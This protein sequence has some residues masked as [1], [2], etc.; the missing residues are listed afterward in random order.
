MLFAVHHIDPG[1]IRTIADLSLLPFTD[2]DDLQ[3]QNQSFIC[4]SSEKII[5]YVTTSGTLGE[6]V[7]V[8]MTEQDLDRLAWNECESLRCAGGSEKEIFQLM[9]TIDRRFMAGLAYFMGARKLGA[10]V[11]RVGNGAPQLQWD[12]IAR[13]KPTI[14]I[15][16]PSFLVKLL[17]YA[18]EHGIDPSLS[19]VR[20]AVCI[21]EPIRN[22]DFT[23]NSLGKKISEQWGIGLYSTYASTEMGAAFTECEAGR[24]GHYQPDLL[25][26][27]LIGEDDKPVAPGQ[28]GELVITTLGV[29]GMPLIRFRTGD[30]CR[31]H[32]EPCSCGRPSMRLGP[33]LGR[34]KQMIKY[35][36]TSL[37]P[38]A[39]CNILNEIPGVSNYLIELSTNKLGTDEVLIRVGTHLPPETIEKVLAEEFRAKLRV[40]PVFS[41]EMPETIQREQI[42]EMSRKPAVIIDK[43]K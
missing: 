43:R 26:A 41:F 36:G 8:V 33:I 24:G 32:T 12:T 31:A 40:I 19:S 30:L 38:P 13:I 14:L 37:Y 7:T 6:P 29:E 3:K 20:K 5:D 23:L 11:V 35:K 9:T 34:K 39:I 4:V 42:T 27:E 2:K 15:A 1:T 18:S 28:M 25:I 16:V 17:D 10:G 22:D 21:G